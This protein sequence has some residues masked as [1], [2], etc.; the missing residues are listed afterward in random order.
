VQDGGILIDRCYEGRV[1]I[2]LRNRIQNTLSSTWEMPFCCR[3]T[4]SVLEREAKFFLIRIST[5]SNRPESTR[6][7]LAEGRQVVEARGRRRCSR[8][9]ATGCGTWKIHN[10]PEIIGSA[11]MRSEGLFAGGATFAP[12]EVTAASTVTT[13]TEPGRPRS[14]PSG[15]AVPEYPGTR[16]R[17]GL[18]SK[19]SNGTTFTLQDLD[20]P[21][22]AMI[23]WA[24]MV[25]L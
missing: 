18:S 8:Y 5:R 24:S 1:T 2:L 19:C 6:L 9:V 15:S 4:V 22:P 10:R 16:R 25:L 17:T 23:P 20:D 14:M 12:G 21:Q 11:C 13:V 7:L 3:N